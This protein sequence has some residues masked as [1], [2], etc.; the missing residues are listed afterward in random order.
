MNINEIK[1][2]YPCIS[3]TDLEL[4]ENLPKELQLDV[5]Y[6]VQ[7]EKY[8]SGVA[9]F[10]MMCAFNGMS[11]DSQSAIADQAGWDDYTTFN[12]AT[13]KEN[14]SHFLID[15]GIPSTDYYPAQFV[16][17]KVGNG[18]VATN[19]IRG[20]NEATSTID[21]EI[22]KLHLAKLRR[23]LKVRL[24]FTLSHYTM[25]ESMAQYLDM[26]GH[27]A[28][29]V[30]YNEKGFIFHDPWDTTWGGTNGGAY[31]TYSYSD[32]MYLF[33][34]VN[35]SKEEADPGGLFYSE[36]PVVKTACLTNSTIEVQ[37]V[38]KWEGVLGYSLKGIKAQNIVVELITDSNLT[39]IGS[40]TVSLEDILVPGGSLITNWKLSTGSASRSFPIEVK[41]TL[42]YVYPAIPWE[43]L[44]E[45]T[46]TFIVKSEN[47]ICLFNESYLEDAGVL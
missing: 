10:Q 11:Y 42:E 26:S 15:N 46:Q 31:V 5:S 7:E 19:I 9:V 8:Y 20:N 6:I 23:P 34:M 43:S 2:F 47:R 25:T 35:Y 17:S 28:L 32:L 41:Y 3:L 38:L 36:I 14:F 24:H 1:S 39:V 30:G 18:V 33:Q 13:F 37:T 40:S 21:F 45:K 4:L 12:H 16:G 29:L 27:C 44:D 22:L